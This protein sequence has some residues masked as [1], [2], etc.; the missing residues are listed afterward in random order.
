MWCFETGADEMLAEVAVA[1]AAVVLD[2]LVVVSDVRLTLEEVVED[3]DV[4]DDERLDVV[5]LAVLDVEEI[6]G[7]LALVLEETVVVAS[8]V[9]RG[10]ADVFDIVK[11]VSSLD[12]MVVAAGDVVEPALPLESGSENGSDSGSKN[13]GK[14]GSRPELGSR[15]VPGKGIGE[16]IG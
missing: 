9:L 7:D 4:I 2:A 8:L 12:A 6:V 16:P 15:S 14:S 1:D 3:V 11:V 10:M 13:G 5:E